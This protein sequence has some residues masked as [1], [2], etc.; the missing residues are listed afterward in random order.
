M[1]KACTPPTHFFRMKFRVDEV[2]RGSV[3]PFRVLNQSG[4]FGS[5]SRQFRTTFRVM[6]P[7]VDLFRKTTTWHCQYDINFC[8]WGRPR[9]QILLLGVPE[10]LPNPSQYEIGCHARRFHLLFS[11]AA[12]ESWLSVSRKHTTFNTPPQWVGMMS[13][14]DEIHLRE[15]L[16]EHLMEVHLLVSPTI[17]PVVPAITM[18]LAAL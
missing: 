1:Y 14:Y 10:A 7:S 4:P 5:S 13:N 16:S 17:T 2:L 11:R 3:E 12:N 15:Q 9:A 6:N 8:I 18:P